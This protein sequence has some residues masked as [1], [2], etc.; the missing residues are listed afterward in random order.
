NMLN[1]D[2][3]LQIYQEAWENDGGVGSAPLRGGRT[4]EQARNTNTD[5]VDETIHLGF[6]Q[7]YNFAGQYG[8]K[9]LKVFS[10]IGYDDNGSYLIGNSYVRS[11]FRANASYELS[12]KLTLSAQTSISEGV[13]NRIDAAWSG[14]LGDAMSTALPY[15]PIFYEDTVFSGGNILHL[16][17]DYF[18]DG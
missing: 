9:R 18:S 10:S 7:A 3:L 2:E 5:W 14:G 17:G 11:S 8:S 16:P 6:K 12:D 1:T 4:W 13:N 15:F